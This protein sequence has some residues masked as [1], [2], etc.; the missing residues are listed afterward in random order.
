ML[1]GCARGFLLAAARSSVPISG[2]QQLEV[3]GSTSLTEIEAEQAQHAGAQMT[4]ISRGAQRCAIGVRIVM[5][6]PGICIG[7][8]S[9]CM[10]AHGTAVPSREPHENSSQALIP[11]QQTRQRPEWR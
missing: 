5:N 8:Y 4:D 9:A 7:C 10:L 2:R 11:E 6:C 3:S 1:T